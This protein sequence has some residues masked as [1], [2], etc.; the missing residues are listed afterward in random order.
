[1]NRWEEVRVILSELRDLS[2]FLGISAVKVIFWSMTPEL[3]L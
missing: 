1:M 2:A 3:D